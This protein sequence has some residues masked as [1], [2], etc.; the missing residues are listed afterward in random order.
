MIGRVT[1]TRPWAGSAIPVGA[2]CKLKDED[3]APGSPRVT[4]R[5]PEPGGQPTRGRGHSLGGGG[6]APLRVA[7]L[8][9]SL[10]SEISLG[11]AP[12]SEASLSL[13]QR[14]PWENCAPIVSHTCPQNLS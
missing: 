11:P 9:S 13:Q 5:A 3:R 8:L 12:P 10:G 2:P 7:G 4:P 14:P 6:W 1:A